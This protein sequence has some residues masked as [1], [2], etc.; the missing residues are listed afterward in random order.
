MSMYKLLEYS[1]NY[2]DTASILWFYFKDEET[3]FSAN[4]S[5]G[6][7]FTSFKY[8]AKLLGN[9]IAGKANGILKSQKIKIRNAFANNMVANL[10]LSKAQISKRTQAQISKITLGSWLSKTKLKT[11]ANL[12][13][14]HQPMLLFILIEIIYPD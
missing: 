8:M 7:A 10:K 5:D 12:A 3:N 9:I 6:N 14:K 13:K 4:N 11:V 2:S 1:S